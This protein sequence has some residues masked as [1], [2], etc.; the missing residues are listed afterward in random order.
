[1][2]DLAKMFDLSEATIRRYIHRYNNTGLASLQP[3]YGSDRPQ[4]LNWTKA[5]WLDVIAQS[6]ANMFQMNP[7]TKN[8]FYYRQEQW[9]SWFRVHNFSFF[10]V[11]LA[12][13]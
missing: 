7:A 13:R 2:P 5:L 6:P 3:V 11:E 12:C 9:G 1:M 8:K 4:L 10:A